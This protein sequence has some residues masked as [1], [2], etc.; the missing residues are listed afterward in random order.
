MSEK[1][2]SLDAKAKLWH[3]QEV[4]YRDKCHHLSELAK[5]ITTERDHLRDEL[6]DKMQLLDDFEMRYHQEYQ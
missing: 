1:I 6:G 4:D 2:V 5:T 3:V